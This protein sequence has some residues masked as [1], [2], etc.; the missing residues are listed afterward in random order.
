M[1][2]IKLFRNRFKLCKTIDDTGW[3]KLNSKLNLPITFERA[4]F[5]SKSFSRVLIFISFFQI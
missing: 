5:K 4:T 1:I 2:L 3:Q